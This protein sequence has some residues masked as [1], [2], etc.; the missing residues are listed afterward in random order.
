MEKRGST[1]LLPPIPSVSFSLSGPDVN[2]LSRVTEWHHCIHVRRGECVG[3]EA[4]V[5]SQPPNLALSAPL[6]FRVRRK[7]SLFWDLCPGLSIAWISHIHSG[8]EAWSCQEYL[9]LVQ[10]WGMGGEFDLI[11]WL[12]FVVNVQ[13]FCTQDVCHEVIYLILSGAS[14]IQAAWVVGVLINCAKGKLRQIKLSFFW[15][16]R[17]SA[18][19]YVTHRFP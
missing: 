12:K 14:Y 19:M 15:D 4:F 17:G 11:L 2:P 5:L 7:S 1:P 3:I 18:G 8:C 16:K 6:L 13:F 10:F 9:G